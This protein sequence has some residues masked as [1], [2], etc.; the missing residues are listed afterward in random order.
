MEL[1]QHVKNILI[2]TKRQG[3]SVLLRPAILLTILELMDFVM[4]V[5]HIIT[6]TLLGSHAHL[7]SVVFSN[8]N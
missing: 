1:A 2:Q 4:H 7:M 8:F 6:K 5:N 3:N